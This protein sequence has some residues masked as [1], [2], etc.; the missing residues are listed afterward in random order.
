MLIAKK[1]L[2]RHARPITSPQTERDGG[3]YGTVRYG[4]NGERTTKSKQTNKAAKED[5]KRCST[6]S[7]A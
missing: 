7:R 1:R 6:A 5:K 4:W 3:R 2:E